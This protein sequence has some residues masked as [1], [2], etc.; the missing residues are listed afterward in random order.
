VPS[1]LTIPGVQV[2][3]QFEPAP[4]LPGATGV[5]GIVGVADRGPVDPTPTGSLG[6]FLDVFGQGS[7]YT[8][9]EVRT[10]FANGV[11]EVYVART[12]P[13]RGQKA[14]LTLQDDEGEQV[15][16]LEARAEGVWGNRIGVAIEQVKTTLGAVKY[17]NLVTSLDGAVVD[18][19]SNLVMDE[20]SPSYFFDQINEGSRLVVAYDPLF[21]KGLPDA[22]TETAFEDSDARAAFATLRAGATD[23]IRADAK[24]AGRA[25]NQISV[26]V[27][28][29]HAALAITGSPGA[30]PSIEVR[31]RT[32]GAAGTQIRVST[33][34]ASPTTVNL[35]VTPAA[36]PPRTIGPAETVADLV[37]LAANDPD[38]E[39]ISQGD[40]LP[41]AAT[42]NLERRVDLSVFTEGRDTRTYPDLSTP[43][44]IAGI[45]DPGVAFG[46]VGGATALPDADQGVPL[47][48]GRNKGPALELTGPA[49]DEPLLELVPAQGVTADLS[50]SLAQT[51]DPLSSQP[52]ASLSV[53]ADGDL[54][55][56]FDGLSLDPDNPGYLPEVVAA[57][58]AFV[59][60]H[61]LFVRSRTTSFPRAISRPVTLGGGAS[62]TAD[63]YQDA[64]DRLE[65][66]EDVD[67]V[68]ASVANQLPDDQAI[69]VHQEVVA[70]CTKM[71]DVARNR[72]GL[73]SVSDAESVAVADILQHADDVRS[74]HFVLVAP[75][76][77]EAALAGLLG[78]QDYFD[79]P[80]FKTIASLGTDPG[81]YS[82]AQLTQ[83]IQGNVCV[84]EQRKRLGIIV[85]KG[86]LTSGRQINVQ[87][88]ANK[89]VRDVKAIADTY[90]GLLNNEGQ[91]NALKQQITALLLQMERDGALVPSTD[92]KEPAFGVDVYSTEADFAN[93]IV[94]VDIAVRPVRAID[95]IYATIL[96]QN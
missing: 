52:A 65:A 75:A 8:L 23:V 84:I 95:F 43:A 55:E 21:E 6:E 33:Q 45:S 41:D 77:T 87:R 86:V 78:R 72:I 12:A 60:A 26:E 32:A 3:T 91:R 15:A 56:T 4:V 68:I 58:S 76:R 46:V 19:L 53:F 57:S 93:G 94:R 30:V 14:T 20:E 69:A 96:V 54:V 39:V 1:P 25:G 70:H 61:D 7:R 64:L 24:R 22:I 51:V 71:A 79:S 10:A 62:P 28:E 31:A 37:A 5:L 35:V 85:V 11:L 73:G 89:A 92:G 36:G 80:T 40:T 18:R 47:A 17:V 29:G 88:T 74:D 67:L 27:V 50:V 44:D 90:I 13:G 59:R 63:D 2:T 9:P 49:S 83:L 81:S 16:T 48:A 82:D 66:A 38:V 34:P 42:H